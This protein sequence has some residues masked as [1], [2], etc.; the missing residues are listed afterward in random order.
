MENS[1]EERIKILEKAAETTIEA[2]G[3]H[4]EVTSEM[5]SIMETFT[6]RVGDRFDWIDNTF[7]YLLRTINR[8]IFL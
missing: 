4:V 7:K 8:I 5:V 2:T 1:Y 6:S 3:K